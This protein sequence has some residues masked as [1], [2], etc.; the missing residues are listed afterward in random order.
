[1]GGCLPLTYWWEDKIMTTS[2]AVLRA[3]ALRTLLWCM[4]AAVMPG[5]ALARPDHDRW[6]ATWATAS[7]VITPGFDIPPA[8]VQPTLQD[9]TLRQIVRIS[10]GGGVFRVW[11]TNEFGTEP[12]PV[13]SAA[14]ALRATNDSIVAGSSR[15]LSF[16]GADSITIPAGARI[17]SDPVDLQAAPRTDLAI[18]LH[19]GA[20]LSQSQSPQTFHVRALQTNYYVNGAGDQT[21]SLALPAPASATQWY[22]LAAVDTLDART[23][24]PLPVVAMLGDSTTDGDQFGF[25]NEPVD[26]NQRPSDYLADLYVTGEKGKSGRAG[27]RRRSLAAVL[28]AGISGN[29]VTASLIGENALARLDR[30]VLSHSGVTHVVVLEGINDLGLGALLQVFGGVF[31]PTFQPDADQIIATHRQIIARAKAKGVEVV[32]A[33]L[34]PSGNASLAPGVPYFGYPGNLFGDAAEAARLAINDWIRN[35]GEYAAVV[36]YDAVLQ[37]PANPVQMNPALTADGLHPNAAG[38]ERMARALYQ[39]LTNSH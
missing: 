32:G 2:I 26:L 1:M 16:G 3:A 5:A 17:V 24:K 8:V 6:I 36:D 18:S 7:K 21:E 20:D 28:N 23:P 13:E 10:A 34:P 22:F 14:L 15:K 27:N 29:Q 38:Y 19:I 37:D 11:L 31:P 4:V 33:T 30:D 25:P 35:S 9:I 12:L 39:V